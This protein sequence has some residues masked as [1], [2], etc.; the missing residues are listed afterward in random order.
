MEIVTFPTLEKLETMAAKVPAYMRPS[1]T[2]SAAYVEG[3][4]TDADCD[5]ISASLA[6]LEPYTH[7]DCGAVT[8]ESGGRPC[9]D[10]IEHVGRGLNAM[11]WGFDLDQD[12]VSWLQT[13]E[14]GGKYQRHMDASPGQ[15]RKFTAVALLTD[16]MYYAGGMLRLFYHPVIFPIP[17]T[18]GTIVVFPSWMEHEVLPITHGHRQTINMGFWGPPFK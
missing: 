2:P 13:Y 17:R 6:G 16:P 11:Y 15:T 10:Q 7:Q 14:E 1:L 18:R 5:E 4:L 8:R 3:W 12:P 9:L